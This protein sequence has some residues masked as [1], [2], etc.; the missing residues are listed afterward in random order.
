[1]ILEGKSYAKL[2]NHKNAISFFD[3]ALKADPQNV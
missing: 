1:M 2:G 3:K